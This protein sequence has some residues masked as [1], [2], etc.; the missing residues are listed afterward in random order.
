MARE[1][2]GFPRNAMRGVWAN[3]TR[4]AIM[5]SSQLAAYDVFKEALCKAAPS[6]FD[7]DAS[8]THFSASTGAGLVATTLCSPVDVLKTQIMKASAEEAKPIAQ[9]LRTN[10]ADHGLMWMFR[11]WVPSFTRLGPQTI[12]TFVILE[13][14]RRLYRFLMDIE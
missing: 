2:G 9:L 12:A 1:P 4:A 13:Q 7:P 14:H 10:F 8:L 5:T 3:A 6:Y 11:G